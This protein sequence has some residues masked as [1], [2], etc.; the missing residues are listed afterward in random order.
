MNKGGI[1]I[2]FYTC[3]FICI[4]IIYRIQKANLEE[5]I[6]F[7]QLPLTEKWTNSQ[8]GCAS[9]IFSTALFS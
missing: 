5:M 7:I 6:S 1:G 8:L 3:L 2:Y 4:H 9:N